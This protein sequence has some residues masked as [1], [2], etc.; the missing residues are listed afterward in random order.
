[1]TIQDLDNLKDNYFFE[2]IDYSIAD[3]LNNHIDLTVLDQY[4]IDKNDINFL[5]I[6]LDSD[7][8]DY[9]SIYASIGY[10]QNSKVYKIY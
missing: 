7:G 3:I 1:M 10:F 8:S 9:D 5:H 6:K 4:N 2:T